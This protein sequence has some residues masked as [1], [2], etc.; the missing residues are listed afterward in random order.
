M[1]TTLATQKYTESLPGHPRLDFT[2]SRSKIAKSSNSI[3]STRA[4]LKTSRF[5]VK[6]FCEGLVVSISSSRPQD[7]ILKFELHLQVPVHCNT[8]KA[9]SW[10]HRHRCQE[11]ECWSPFSSPATISTRETASDY[12]E[13]MPSANVAQQYWWVVELAIVWH[14]LIMTRSVTEGI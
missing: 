12:T 10:L 11:S 3:K 9:R 8:G 4:R 14:R 5:S 7:Q 13:I 2:R 6:A 1:Y